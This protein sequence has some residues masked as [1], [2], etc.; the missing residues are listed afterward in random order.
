[1]WLTVWLVEGLFAI[2]IG[3]AGIW[4]K[5]REAGLPV[6]SGPAR[7]FTTS[8][9]PPLLVGALLTLVFYR[10]GNI[11]PIGGMW[12]LLYGTAIVAGGAF[13]VRVIPVMGFCFLSLGAVALFLPLDWVNASLGVGFGVLHIVFGAV[14]ARR[15]GG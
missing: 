7:K 13:S 11:Q 9:L 2:G 8:F 5:A 4:Q 3:A 1:M 12:L 14:I 15:Y 10:N 6:L